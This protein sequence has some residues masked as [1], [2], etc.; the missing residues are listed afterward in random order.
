MCHQS[1][2]GKLALIGALSACV[3]LAV[4]PYVLSV[5]SYPMIPC[6]VSSLVDGRDLALGIVG[7][8][9]NNH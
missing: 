9:V 6:R 4:V 2:W 7:D 5:Q 3:G 1:P 8:T